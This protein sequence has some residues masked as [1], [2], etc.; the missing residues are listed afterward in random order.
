MK[1]KTLIIN[2]CFTLLAAIVLAACCDCGKQI[3]TVAKEKKVITGEFSWQQ[4][5]KQA[6]WKSYEPSDFAPDGE[7]LVK[8]GRN[9]DEGGWSFL[10]F[11][12][13]WCG[14]SE[15]EVPKIY[16]IFEI[17]GINPN[18]IT[19][20]GV[21]RNKR[22]PSGIAEVYKIEKVPTLIILHNSKET[23]RIVEFPKKSWESD[24]VEILEK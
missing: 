24:L 1:Y 23:G 12:G 7:S 4:W 21:D 20:F 19:L 3:T 13:S 15:T 9:L 6:E 5:Q 11:A 22:E 10:L 16:K 18:I 14:D 2:L 17:A 8:F